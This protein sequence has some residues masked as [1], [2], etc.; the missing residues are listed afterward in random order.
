MDYTVWLGALSSAPLT[1][2]AILLAVM[3]GW[4]FTPPYV[5]LL[6]EMLDERNDRIA[7][8]EADR[9]RW[10]EIVEGELRRMVREVDGS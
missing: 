10:R 6:R 5:A 2:A 7:T 1:A 4:L 3:Q 9:D 8:L